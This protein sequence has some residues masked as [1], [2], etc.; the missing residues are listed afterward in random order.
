MLVVSWNSV[1]IFNQIEWELSSIIDV[2]LKVLDSKLIG[3]ASG[4]DS[5]VFY[6]KMEGDYYRYLAEFKTG[7]ERK[8]VI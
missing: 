2:I 7:D 5:N 6:L 8:L 4:G 1:V 3:S